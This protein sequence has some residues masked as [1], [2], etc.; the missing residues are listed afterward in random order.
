MLRSMPNQT[1]RPRGQALVVFS[2]CVLLLV[3]MVMMTLSIGSRVRDKLELD[4]LAEVSAYNDA[5]LVARTF[6]TVS[7]LNRAMISHMVALAGVQ[8]LISW[9]GMYRGALAG[10]HKGLEGAKAPH[11]GECDDQ[12]MGCG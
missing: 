3:V 7:M 11:S 2:L 10:T 8:S 6:N 1:K 12:G 5:V 4:N 9:A